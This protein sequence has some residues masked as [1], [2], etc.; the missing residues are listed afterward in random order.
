M[1]RQTTLRF[2]SPSVLCAC[3]LSAIGGRGNAELVITAGPN[4]GVIS[5]LFDVSQGVTVTSH[6]AL[7][8]HL[9][10]SDV[11]SAIGFVN[12]AFV[13]PYDTIF[14]DNRPV[15]SLDF[16]EFRT[17]SPVALMSFSLVLSDDSNTGST[18]RASSH[19]RLLWSRD[20][21]SFE[22][23]SEG[24]LTPNYEP[25]YGHSVITISDLALDLSGHASHFRLE[26]RRATTS[27]P[28][29]IELDGF[30]VYA[31][32]E[33]PT[34]VLAVLGFP[35]LSLARRKLCAS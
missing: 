3:A 13:E 2:L 33:P 24:E 10:G 6:S 28:R 8:T 30:G 27:G 18:N 9:G 11:R 5:D 7:F 21:S 14:A 32:P 31:V 15:G 16:I 26:L 1:I 34:F 22:L 23:I 4:L 35:I 19:F 29:I 17:T 25:T 12:I 20:G